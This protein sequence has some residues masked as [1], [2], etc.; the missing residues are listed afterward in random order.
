MEHIQLIKVGYDSNQL[1]KIKSGKMF[2]WKRISEF[3]SKY[4]RYLLE[5]Y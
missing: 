3:D 2:K 5:N 1:I 4:L